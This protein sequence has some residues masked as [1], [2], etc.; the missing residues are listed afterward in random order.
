MKSGGKTTLPFDPFALAQATGDVAMS[1]AMRP[2]D[3][4]QVQMDAAKQWG[5]FWMG[6]MSG[7]AGDA[8][9]DRR[10]MSADWQDDPYYRGV[11]DSYLLA[12]K[13]LRELISLGDGDEFEQ[14]DRSLPA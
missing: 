13:Q 8:P 9:R 5:D 14:G 10:F 6:A 1:I 3:L 2:Q 12:S 4:L 11:R 7:K